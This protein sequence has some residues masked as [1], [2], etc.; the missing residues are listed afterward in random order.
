MYPII[1]ILNISGMTLALAVAF[2][3]LLYTTNELSF[4]RHHSKADRTYRMTYRFANES[5]YDIH[6]AR[7]NQEWVN[8]FPEVF[9][10]VEAL[11]RFQSFRPRN[12]MVGEKKF[13]E[14]FAYAVD[15]TVFEIFDFDFLFG[16]PK[17]ALQK[18]YSMVLTA[19]TAK[20]YFGNLDPM[21]KEVIIINEGNEENY[22]VTGIIEDPSERSHMPITFL[23]SINTPEQRTGW[24]YIYFLL[25]EAVGIK[26]LEQKIPDFIRERAPEDA[27]F[28][29]VFFQPLTSIHLH[30]NLSRELIPNGNYQYVKLFLIVAILLVLIAGINFANLNTVKTLGRSKEIGLRRVIG[31]GSRSIQKVF[32]A[33]SFLMVLISA[34]LAIAVTVLVFDQLEGLFGYHPQVEWFWLLGFALCAITFVT[35]LSGYYPAALVNR[36]HPIRAMAGDFSNKLGQG[37]LRKLLVGIQFIIVLSLLSATL[38]IHRQFTF[39]SERNLGFDE[40]NLLTIQHY[41]YPLNSSY[42]TFKHKLLSIP[43]IEDVTAVMELP[44]IPIKDEGE[45]HVQGTPPEEFVTTD[46]QVMDVNGLQVLG[47]DLIAGTALPE[48]LKNITNDEEQEFMEFLQTK[49]RGYL[50]NESAVQ[51]LGF[52]NPSEILDQEI[53]WAIGDL[54]LGYGPVTGVIRDYHQESLQADIDPVVITYEPIWLQNI[55]LKTAGAEITPIRENIKALWN[56]QYPQYPFELS[57]MDSHVEHTYQREKQQRTLMTYF[58]VLSLVITTL[59]LIGLIAYALEKRLRE[60]AIR[61]VL[62]ANLTEMIKLLG[63]EYGKLVL[64]SAAIAIPVVWYFSLQWLRG[65][66][67]HIS[68]NGVSFVISIALLTIILV[69]ILIWQTTKVNLSNPTEVLKRE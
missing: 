2:A 33:E 12:I 38:I 41:H 61:R 53:S 51:L 49:P 19:K 62:G 6:W 47:M 65:Y 1:N 20:K 55:I 15:P 25:S 34:V 58:T 14:E 60:L 45:V 44:T 23:S 7:M 48:R 54:R 3:A 50:V 59:G 67:Y 10:E 29:D 42:E 8:D 26:Q 32:F 18:P 11:V 52:E 37:K 17:T 9:P 46:I 31:A 69:A 4:D 24:A 57:F 5:G 30:S 64:A 40:Q 43:G 56:E 39:M 66:A 28:L 21:G 13:R 27:D 16:D 36:I 35:F 68:I 22:K 63:S